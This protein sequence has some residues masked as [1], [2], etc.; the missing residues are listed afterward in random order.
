M[1]LLGVV[2]QLNF[3]Q[4]V[5]KISN[6]KKNHQES[7]RLSSVGLYLSAKKEDNQTQTKPVK[8]QIDPRFKALNILF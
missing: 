8:K 3:S 4:L 1:E 6:I 2:N 5:Q 7:S